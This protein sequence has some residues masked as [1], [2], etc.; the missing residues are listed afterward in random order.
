MPGALKIRTSVGPDV[1]TIAAVSSSISGTGFPEG[2]TTAPVGTKYIDTNAT[3]GAIEWIKATG[4]GNTGWKTS[5]ADTGWRD[6]TG[7]LNPAG[8]VI[9][10]GGTYNLRRIND[11]VW[12]KAFSL[13]TSVNSSGMFALWDAIPGAFIVDAYINGKA[14]KSNGVAAE[15][16]MIVVGAV[17]YVSSAAN[18]AWL[19]SD[20]LQGIFSGVTNQPWPTSLPGIAG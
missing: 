15:Y 4:S 14:C 13:S 5:Y 7:L 18:G 1:W 8:G 9:I 6:V 2:V 10:N 12:H 20:A 19:A 16:K 3:N 17:I 11:T